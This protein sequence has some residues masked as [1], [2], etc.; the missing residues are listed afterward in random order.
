MKKPTLYSLTFNVCS[1]V[2][3]SPM[4]GKILQAFTLSTVIHLYKI[5]QFFYISDEGLQ[6]PNF[7]PV[8]CFVFRLSHTHRD[9]VANEIKSLP[10]S[11]FLSSLSI[12]HI[13]TGKDALH[14]A[15]KHRSLLYLEGSVLK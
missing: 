3:D 10:L 14:G 13:L 5:T 8:S 12:C 9:S 6:T 11:H 4:L 7:H 1:L 15:K 2:L